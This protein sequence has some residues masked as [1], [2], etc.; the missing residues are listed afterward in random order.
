MTP[1]APT[2]PVAVV[3]AQLDAY[4][5]HDVERFA[6]CY[7]EDVEVFRPPAAEPA[8]RGRA[9]LADYYARNR[10]NIPA[11]HA[12]LVGRLAFGNKVVDQERITGLE[13]PMPPVGAVYEVLDGKIRRVW[14]FSGA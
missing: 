13:P 7:A 4:N 14:F 5:D 6:A 8:I 11:L 1:M 9:A 10:F 12:E 2:D 3:Q